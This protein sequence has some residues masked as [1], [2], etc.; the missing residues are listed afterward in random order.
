[1]LSKDW[2]RDTKLSCMLTRCLLPLT[3]S[4]PPQNFLRIRPYRGGPYYGELR[5]FELRHPVNFKSGYVIS[6]PPPEL[7]F[8]IENL[9]FCK[10]Q[11]PLLQ[12]IPIP[13][14]KGNFFSF[15]PEGYRLVIS[16]EICLQKICTVLFRAERNSVIC[17]LDSKIHNSIKYII[18]K[19]TYHPF[20]DNRLECTLNQ[21]YGWKHLL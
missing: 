9:A 6:P 13:H 5:H 10:L 20:N 15:M 17:F 21:I 11:I 19:R 8:L 7:D 4:S 12:I 16:C 2:V 18:F 3:T 1:M 14:Q